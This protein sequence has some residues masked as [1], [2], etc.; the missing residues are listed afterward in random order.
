MQTPPA[1][2]APTVV[3]VDRI[4]AVSDPVVRNLQITQCYHEL[5]RAMGARDWAHLPDRM[6]FIADMFWRYHNT[7]DLFAPP[8]TPAQI[9]ALKAGRVPD[10]R[11]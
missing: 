2:S 10:G 1:A 4:A 6:H 11:L 9:T 3:D 8:F 5:A 7:S